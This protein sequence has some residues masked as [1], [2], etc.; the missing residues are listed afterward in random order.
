MITDFLASKKI[1]FWFLALIVIFLGADST[2]AYVASSSN[3]RLERDSLNSGG[4]DLATST[5][6]RTTSTLG[7]ISGLFLGFGANLAAGYR[8][9]DSTQAAA[10]P[11]LGCTDSS[12]TNYDPLATTDDGSCVFPVGGGQGG[13]SATTTPT[14]TNALTF[15]AV[16][17][18]TTQAINLAWT[19]PQTFDQIVIVRRTDRL[20]ANPADGLTVYQGSGEAHLDRLNLQPNTLYRYVLFVIVNDQHSSG[21]AATAQTPAP[22]QKEEEGEEEEDLPAVIPGCL[23]P[24]ATNFNPAATFHDNSC[25][26][27][28]GVAPTLGPGPT[29]AAITPSPFTQET[30]S[31]VLPLIKPESEAWLLRF[32]QP[33]RRDQTFNQRNEV[34]LR[35]DLPLTI[36]FNPTQA[37]LGLKTLGV[38]LTADDGATFSFL[39]AF[40]PQ[41]KTYEATLAPLARLGTYQFDLYVIDYDR[42]TTS[43][44]QGRFLIDSGA[45][46]SLATLERVAPPAV[47]VGLSVGFLP[48]VYDGLIIL[49]RTLPYLFGR[50]RRK[51]W[52]T[53]YD[54]VTKRP[55]D[56]A[57]VTVKTDLNNA[58]DLASAITDRD[59][60]FGFLLPA[61]TYY[62]TAQKTHYR[63]PSERLKG[64]P[65]DELYANL[66]FGEAITT[67]GV[68]V[69]NLNIPMDPLDFD[70]NEFVKTQTDFFRFY[71]RR[72]LWLARFWKLVFFAGLGFSLYSFFLYPSAWNALFI[73]LYGVVWLLDRYWRVKRKPKVVRRR[74]TLDPL[75][76][77][78]IKV[79]LPDGDQLI[80]SVAA[81]RLGRFWLL[82]RPGLYRLTVEEKRPDGSYQ[83]VWTS[84]VTDWP[85]GVLT[86]DVY[87]E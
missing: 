43:H 58:K 86:E 15:T 61:G 53:V 77:A 17:A 46:F 51:P 72:D 75:P 42:Q 81:D 40:N 23:D 6:Y 1:Y 32:A 66:Y 74:A 59:G 87:V 45:L 14:V 69:V 31:P 28:R 62:L 19:N 37:P 71:R 21:L 73:T 16:Y 38:T 80:K 36:R 34:R 64:Q 22:P 84:P 49:F 7:E 68:E 63:F 70:W 27:E 65:A 25:R 67:Q 52:G 47:A 41:T 35:G 18:T 10:E 12:A 60:R 82:V 79:W 48:T 39:L 56:P 44:L 29:T 76:F 33:G 2:L 57:Y 20:A 50:R 5:N 9:L 83:K 11:V 3:Y 55:L 26:Y 13:P 85:K 30:L 78:L 54:S 8:Y 24:V 4:V